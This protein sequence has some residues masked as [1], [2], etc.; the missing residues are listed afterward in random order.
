[1]IDT[2]THKFIRLEQAYQYLRA[3]T[4]NK[5]LTAARIYLLRD[6]VAMKRL[7]DEIGP[8][9]LWDKKKFDVMYKLLKMKFEQNPVLMEM[10]IRTGDCELVE[11]TPKGSG[12]WGHPIVE[13]AS[14]TRVAWTK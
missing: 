5:P 9:D 12:M 1:M 11:A 10:L 3:K 13:P 14:S 4:L 7:G 6:P 8:S 2:G